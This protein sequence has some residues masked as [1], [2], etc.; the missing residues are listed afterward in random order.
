[1]PSSTPKFA[2]PYPVG[3]DLL[4]D[5]DNAMQAL[6]ERVEALLS[7]Q[8][9]A[10]VYGTNVVTAYDGSAVYK[11]G[12]VIVLRFGLTTTVGVASGGTLLTTPV[13]FRPIAQTRC[14]G[15]NVTAGLWAVGSYVGF[16]WMPT[17][18]LYCEGATTNGQGFVGAITSVIP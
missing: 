3:T 13:G 12:G 6:A 14:V 15:W 1:M 5:G 4:A 18:V 2:I 11:S 16:S 9:G 17:G 7:P 10:V 8:T